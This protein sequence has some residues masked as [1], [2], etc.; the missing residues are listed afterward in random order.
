[1]PLTSNVRPQENKVLVETVRS[2]FNSSFKWPLIVLIV[3]W[4]L[5]VGEFVISVGNSF[6]TRDPRLTDG[7]KKE[8]SLTSSGRDVRI[9]TLERGIGTWGTKFIATLQVDGDVVTLAKGGAV[10]QTGSAFKLGGQSLG[11]GISDIDFWMVR[12]VEPKGALEERRYK[13][14]VRFR[15]IHLLL[16]NEQAELLVGELLVKAPIP[17]KK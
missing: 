14:Y 12:E 9:A 7:D 17:L 13:V 2:V 5:F 8:L 4:A 3:Y 10:G 6:A 11:H 1:V 16:F 15:R